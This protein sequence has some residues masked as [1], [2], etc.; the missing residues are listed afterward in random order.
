MKIFDRFSW[1]DAEKR[2]GPQIEDALDR[3]QGSGSTLSDFAFD[4]E[5]SGGLTIGIKEGRTRYPYG[6]TIGALV[7]GG[8]VTLPDNS[9]NYVYFDTIDGVVK[10]QFVTDGA[11]PEGAVPALYV[12]TLDGEIVWGSIQDIRIIFQPLGAPV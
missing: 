12:P 8:Q 1:K 5:N 9:E 11:L 2:A 4:E 7:S 6:G 3:V 10:S